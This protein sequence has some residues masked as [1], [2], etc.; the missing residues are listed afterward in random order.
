MPRRAAKWN[1]LC[2]AALAVMAGAQS[3]AA[4]PQTPPASGPESGTSI[5]ITDISV[6][7][8]ATGAH[9]ANVGVLIQGDRIASVGPGIRIPPGATRLNGKGKFLIPGLWDMHYEKILR[10]PGIQNHR[11]GLIPLTWQAARAATHP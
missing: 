3:V 10:L 5:A 1:R 8:V 11:N 6:I 4:P 9:H 2:L 7:D